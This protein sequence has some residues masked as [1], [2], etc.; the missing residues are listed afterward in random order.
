MDFPVINLLTCLIS[1]QQVKTAKRL[2]RALA[3]KEEKEITHESEDR[4]QERNRC[5]CERNNRGDCRRI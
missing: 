1:N 3:S 4:N 2:S 5:R